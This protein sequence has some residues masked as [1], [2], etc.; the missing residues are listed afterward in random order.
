MDFRLA[1]P[2]GYEL[3]GATIDQTL[4][5]NRQNGGKTVTTN[6]PATAVQ[7]ADVVYTEPP[8]PFWQPWS[9]S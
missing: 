7:N 6:L 2:P 5:L 4:Q 3:D 8:R 1:S 9:G